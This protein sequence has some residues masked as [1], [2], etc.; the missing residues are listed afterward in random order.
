MNI[1]NH[2]VFLQDKIKAMHE[3]VSAKNDI[4]TV[5]WSADYQSPNFCPIMQ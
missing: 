5:K 2:V 4:M 1:A 3:T